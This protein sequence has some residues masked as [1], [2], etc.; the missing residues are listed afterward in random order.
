M[1]T[2]S[3]PRQRRGPPIASPEPGKTNPTQWE[4]VIRGE[5][6]T[7]G[8][9]PVLGNHVTVTTASAHDHPE[10]NV[11]KP[12]IIQN[13][14]HS[15]QIPGDSSVSLTMASWRD[16]NRIARNSPR[17]SRDRSSS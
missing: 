15:I 7:R 13:V 11:F 9:V 14:P 4:V 2:R 16:R 8:A 3:S 10:F 12:V 1:A 17:T 6:V 5:V